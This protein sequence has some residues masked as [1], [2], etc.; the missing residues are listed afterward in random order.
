MNMNHDKTS[1]PGKTETVLFLCV[2]NSA[3]SQMAEGLARVIL[4]PDYQVLSAGSHPAQVNPLA[5]R[6]MAELGIDLSAHTSKSVES[7]AVD[8]LDWVITLCAE[9][10]CP[11]LPS[12]ARHLHWPIQD[13]ARPADDEAQA[14]EQFRVAR[15]WLRQQIQQWHAQSLTQQA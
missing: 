11:L 1:G 14:L 4:G 7:I 8:D 15:D 12:R 13:P 6:A 3:R 2:A 9:E 10:V 5:I